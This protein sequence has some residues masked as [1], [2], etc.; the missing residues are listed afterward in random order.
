MKQECLTN[1]IAFLN[2]KIKDKQLNLFFYG[3]LINGLAGHASFELYVDISSRNTDLRLTEAEMLD[4]VYGKLVA[5]SRILEEEYQM[6]V[7]Y[8]DKEISMRSVAMRSEKKS[9]DI[10]FTV[11]QIQMVKESLFKQIYCAISRNF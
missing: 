2:S 1:I 10:K 5:K 9:L 11:N 7:R 4:A 3:P 8:V 6:D